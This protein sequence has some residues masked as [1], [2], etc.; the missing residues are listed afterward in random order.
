MKIVFRPFR[1]ED[2]GRPMSG[3]SDLGSYA[4]AAR[5]AAGIVT[6]FTR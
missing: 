6:T 3:G 2:P 1:A 4:G 5:H